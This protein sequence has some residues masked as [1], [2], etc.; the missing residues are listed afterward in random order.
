MKKTLLLLFTIVSFGAYAQINLNQ[1]LIA[2]YPF[3]GNANDVSGNNINGTVSNAT[4][5]TDKAGTAN[6]AYYFNGTNAHIL[7]PFSSFIIL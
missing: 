6:S 3:N 4:L 1:G 2:H 7:L 5:T